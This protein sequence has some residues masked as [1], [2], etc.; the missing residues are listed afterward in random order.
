IHRDIKPSNIM[1][2]KKGRL[3]LLDFGAVKQA[4]KGGSASRSTGIFSQGFAPPEQVS[5][6]Q[7]YPS[8]D[9]YAL[10][11]TC[12][13]L[14]TGKDP[15]SLYDSYS[16]TWKWEQHAQVSSHLRQVL[17]RMLM[18]SASDRFQS[19]EQVVAALQTPAR[20]G[21]SPSSS[22]SPRS[23]SPPTSPPSANQPVVKA[24]ALPP[25]STLDLLR[26]AALTGFEAGLLAIGLLS[27]LGTALGSGF[28]LVLLGVLW[29]LQ[30]RRIVDWKDVLILSAITL[31]ILIF[32]P[33]LRQLAWGAGAS[34]L[35][36]SQVLFI[37]VM[38]GLAAIAVTALFKL[39]YN[40]VSKIL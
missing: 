24:P 12:I 36:V 25:R 2:H 3:Y 16:N 19:A 13:M 7:V 23:A 39:V 1:R 37:A 30:W 15:T 27:L 18:P 9:L 21:H 26:G 29:F 5:G 32:L 17:N 6:A 10:A 11:V 28:W 14:L 34:L 31:A 8:S 22:P 33:V 4:T 40:L 20:Q 38:V 35:S